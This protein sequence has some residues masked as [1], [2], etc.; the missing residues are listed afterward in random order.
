MSDEKKKLTVLLSGTS[1]AS[2]DNGWFELGCEALRAKGINRA[3]GG[4]AIADV[5]NRMSRGDLYS[6]EEL[7]EVDVFVIMQVHNRDVYAP[8]ELKKDYHEYA[9]PFTRGNYAAAFDYVIKKYI[10]DCYQLQFDKGSK[11]YGVKGGKPA[12][13]LLCTHWHDA[14]VVYNESIR[15]LSDKWGFP[16]VKFDEQIGFSKTVEHPETHRQTST[17]FADDTECIDGVEYGWHPNRG[18]DCYIQNRMAAVFVAQIQS[19]V[20]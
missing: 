20:L 18:K 9:L 3:I 6:R 12:V 8:N 15:K 2:V 1:F 13:I 14:R 16:L 10:S 7:D 17:L 5:A 19:L 4:E 11:Y